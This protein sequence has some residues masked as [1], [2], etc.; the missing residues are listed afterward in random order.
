MKYTPFFLKFLFSMLFLILANLSVYGALIDGLETYLKM[1]VSTTNATQS[2]GSIKRYNWSLSNVSTI[3]DGKITDAYYFERTNYT[4]MATS[5]F[6]LSTTSFSLWYRPNFS[7]NYLQ[8]GTTEWVIYS[9]YQYGF[10]D[11]NSQY[12]RLECSMK[13][14]TDWRRAYSTTNLVAGTWYHIVCIGGL[15]RPVDMFINGVNQTS[16]TA[17]GASFA[18]GTYNPTI[19][20][21]VDGSTGANG[22][23]DEFGL[24][25]RSLSQAEIDSLYS[26]G[27]G[28]TYPFTGLNINNNTW[29][30][31]SDGGCNEWEDSYSNYCNTTDGTPQITFGTSIIANC[32]FRNISHSYDANYNCSTTNA[33][34][35]ICNLYDADKL[36]YG[37]QNLFVSCTD[38][39]YNTNATNL[40]INMTAGGGGGLIS[41][42][43][44]I[45]TSC[46][47]V[48]T[49]NCAQIN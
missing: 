1:D 42:V 32:S 38:G 47:A 7:I 37:T 9:N 4:S 36:A 34:N 46:G 41:C 18:S 17:M 8:A 23:I 44:V 5:A 39:T 27:N 19:G 35:H 16:S 43:N 25:N 33:Y 20:T 28:I 31:T 45:N 3:L 30:M 49:N 10:L 22:T 2:L 12:D 13:D 6:D 11:W 21:E 40:A 24:W 48:V 14:T 29:N 15:N 26:A